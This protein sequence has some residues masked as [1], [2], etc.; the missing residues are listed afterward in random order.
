[1]ELYM[2]LLFIVKSSLQ[3]YDQPFKGFYEARK[4]VV[5]KIYTLISQELVNNIGNTKFLVF[6]LPLE[7]IACTLDLS[8]SVT[9]LL[10]NFTKIYNNYFR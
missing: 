8:F 7:V 2:Y 3:I 6:S 5:L 10:K 4:L 9:K 1:M